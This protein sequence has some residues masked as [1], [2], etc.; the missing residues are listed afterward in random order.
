MVYCRCTCN[1]LCSQDAQKFTIRWWY[2]CSDNDYCDDFV[3]LAE[4]L[5]HIEKLTNS[6]RQLDS[7]EYVYA[8]CIGRHSLE[9]ASLHSVC[10]RRWN[11]VGEFSDSLPENVTR[12]VSTK[13]RKQAPVPCSCMQ[14]EN[15]WYDG[16]SL[17]TPRPGR[18][19]EE[20]ITN[21][22]WIEWVKDDTFRF[23][24]RVSLLSSRGQVVFHEFHELF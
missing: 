18:R 23:M 24:A 16:W 4:K 7:N 2:I 12:S 5:W 13:N 1:N 15:K 10:R 6:E 17:L 11:G 22:E 9:T 3:A 19:S 14:H 21:A 20:G 8:Q